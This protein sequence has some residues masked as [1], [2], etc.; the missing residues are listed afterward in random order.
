[1]FNARARRR[2]QA[3]YKIEKSDE[4]TLGIQTIGRWYT[5]EGLAAGER[6]DDMR[7]VPDKSSIG[8]RSS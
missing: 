3:K 5:P 1:M 4:T 2:S 8:S 6:G 7:D